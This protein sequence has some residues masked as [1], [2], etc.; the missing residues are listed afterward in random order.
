M[1]AAATFWA[2]CLYNDP[3]A[4]WPERFAIYE[5]CEAARQD[6][7]DPLAFPHEGECIEKETEK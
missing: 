7:K 5:A 4:C 6:E 1:I 3:S 2:V